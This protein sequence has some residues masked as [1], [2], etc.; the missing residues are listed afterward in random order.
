MNLSFNLNGFITYWPYLQ[1]K[2]YFSLKE[3]KFVIN[4]ST[5]LNNVTKLMII[6]FERRKFYLSPKSA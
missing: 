1:L 6:N 2:Y 3:K 5:Y 4:Y